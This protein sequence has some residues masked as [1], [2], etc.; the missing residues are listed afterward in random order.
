M[1]GYEVKYYSDISDIRRQLEE[2]NKLMAIRL[3][4]V[5]DG[6][7]VITPEQVKFIERIAK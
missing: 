3:L 4:L 5:I 6:P 1:T 7:G 2:K